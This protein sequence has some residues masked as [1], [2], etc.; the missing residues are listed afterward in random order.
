MCTSRTAGRVGQR[1]AGA[2]VLGHG[3]ARDRKQPRGEPLLVSKPWEPTL[4]ADQTSCRTSSTSGHFTGDHAEQLARVIEV[5]DAIE[6]RL[7]AWFQTLPSTTR[8]RR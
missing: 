5:R 1:V 2:L 4:D 7:H 3:A 8:D 6:A